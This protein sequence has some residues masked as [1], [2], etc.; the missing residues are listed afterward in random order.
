MLSVLLVLAF[1]GGVVLADAASD[2][3][4]IFGAEAKKV[5]ASRSKTDNAAFA[6][7][8]LKAAK[9]MPDSPAR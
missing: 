4:T 3:E 7:K 2:Y 1:S 9:D 5:A 8:L 6:A